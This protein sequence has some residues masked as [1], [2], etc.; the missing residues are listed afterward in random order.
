MP[1]EFRC[2]SCGAAISTFLRAGEIVQC[3]SCGSGVRVP[4]DAKLQSTQ[5]AVHEH[6]PKACAQGLSSDG[7]TAIRA[8]RALA[9]IILALAILGSIGFGALAKFAGT[10]GRIAGVIFI[11]F[12]GIVECLFLLVV[13]GIAED[14]RKSRILAVTQASRR[15]VQKK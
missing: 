4:D 2:P 6:R 1:L 12:Q 15:E 8:L 10:A 13:A 14:I 5:S 3:S 11:L 7:L 9:W